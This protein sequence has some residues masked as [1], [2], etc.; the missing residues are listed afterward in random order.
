MPEVEQYTS[1][2]YEN[3]GY[4]EITFPDSLE[5]TQIPVAIKEQMFAYS[6]CFSQYFFHSLVLVELTGAICGCRAP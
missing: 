5:N 1:V 2:V 3:R 6:H 4:M